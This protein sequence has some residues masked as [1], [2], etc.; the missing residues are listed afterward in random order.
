MEIHYIGRARV[1]Q[2][3]ILG[4]VIPSLNTGNPYYNW[5]IN[6]YYGVYDPPLEY[7]SNGTLDPLSTLAMMRCPQAPRCYKGSRKIHLNSGPKMEEFGS[8]L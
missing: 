5:C 6:P 3:L 2:L 8:S 7:V 1:D 4:M